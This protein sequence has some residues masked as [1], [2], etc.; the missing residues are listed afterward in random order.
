[1]RNFAQG[2]FFC[3][4]RRMRKMSTRMVSATNIKLGRNIFINPDN[5][6]MRLVSTGASV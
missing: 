1:M 5:S 4:L 3:V 6:S 2:L